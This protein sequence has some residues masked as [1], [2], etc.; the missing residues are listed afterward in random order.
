[1]F[2]SAAIA[3]T[4]CWIALDYFTAR[5]N[6]P[7]STSGARY[8]HA[9]EKNVIRIFKN[10]S[11]S[12]V[13][14]TTLQSGED[15]FDFHRPRQGSGSGFVW[16]KKGHIVTNFHVVRNASTIRVRLPD[17]S[18]WPAQLVGK[19]E[20]KDLAVLR[21]RAP[22][23]KLFPI[24]IGRSND[25]QVGQSVLAIGNPFGLERTLTVGVVSALNRQIKSRVGLPIRGVIQT[26][27]AINP[28]NS[29]GP[30]L[31]SSG[32][33]I[34]I[35]T[36]ILST[37]RASAGIGF[38]VPVDT[39]F[40]VIP[41][42]IQFGEIRRPRLGIVPYQDPQM[43]QSLGKTGVMVGQV[44][45]R[46]P[47]ALAGIQGMRTTPDG[48]IVLGDIII[49]IN[50]QRIHSIPDLL[51]VLEHFKIGDTIAILVDRGGTQRTVNIRL[52]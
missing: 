32:H 44:Q 45:P 17:H 2:L 52:Q 50:K 20:G 41:Q 31:D 27:A 51:S 1:M 18:T 26:D 22:K 13:F 12:V 38:A 46:S 14:I 23:A 36:A 10:S 37:S 3:S 15:F 33:L 34:G 40:T 29:G 24:K 49:A 30:L 35:N 11:R 7:L 6:K 8:L 42:L 47:A 5:A 48:D 21:I 28:G 25:L 43:M 9:H 16:D 4:L 39:I 19:A